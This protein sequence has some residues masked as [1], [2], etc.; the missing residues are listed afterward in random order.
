MAED[1][2]QEKTEF[3]TDKKRG[4]MRSEGN[5]P[6]SKEVNTAVMLGAALWFFVILGG[7]FMHSFLTLFQKGLKTPSVWVGSDTFAGLYVYWVKKYLF[8]ISPLF[9]VFVFF[10][11][12]TNYAQVGWLVAW[13]GIMPK[14]SKLNPIG[15]LKKYVSLNQ[16]VELAKSLFKILFLGWIAIK[17][18]KPEIPKIVMMFHWPLQDCLLFGASLAYKVVV[19]VWLAVIFM[20][21]LDLVFQRWN[22]ERQMKMT[23]QEV[24]DENK[25]QEGDPKMKARIRGVQMEQARKRMM[26]E[27]PLADVVVTN[28]LHIAVALRY[29]HNEDIAPVV[30]AKGAGLLCNKIKELARENHI[31]IIENPTLA[32]LLYRDVDMGQGIPLE[33]YRTVAEILAY[34]YRLKGQVKEG[35]AD[36]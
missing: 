36:G 9:A 5:V 14:F 23:K 35:V 30:I 34:V 6:K 24:Q 15:G 29:K 3:A 27:V 28:P 26:Q 19:R 1:S 22:Y 20:A 10:A 25:Q 32:R 13:K 2:G 7:Q 8:L 31:P 16:L 21:I 11:I 12:Y 4:E 33:V 18:I 17:A